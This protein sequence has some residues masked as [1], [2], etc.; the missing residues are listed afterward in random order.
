MCWLQCRIGKMLF[1]V[2]LQDHFYLLL[3]DVVSVQDYYPSGCCS[4][5]GRLM[6]VGIDM[7]LMSRR[8]QRRW[9][10]MEIV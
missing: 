1:I 2:S 3:L 10:R 7:D 9:I 4:R 5:G 6:L 8:S